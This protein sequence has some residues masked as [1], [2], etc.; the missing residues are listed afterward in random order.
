METLAAHL[1]S[2]FT[3][4]PDGDVEV[5]WQGGEPTL[6]GLDFFTHVV[7]IAEQVRRPGQTPRY[8]LQTNGTLI[9]DAWAQFLAENDFL[10]G[11]SVD[12]PAHLHD[13]F[14]TNVG[15]RETYAM[16]KRGWDTLQRHGVETNILCTVNAANQHHPLEVYRH[17]RDDLGARYIQF[18]PIVER[19]TSSTIAA[20]ERGW[21]HA[22]NDAVMYRQEGDLV[23]RRSVDPES[24]GRFLTVVF[25]EWVNHDVGEVSILHFDAMIGNVFGQSI[26]CVHA[27][28][29]GRQLV[30]NVDGDVYACDHYVEP[31]YRRGNVRS[32]T[33][34]EILAGDAQ[35]GF[36]VA[37][38]STLT[39]QCRDCRVRWA[40]HGGCPKDRFGSSREGE[41]GHSYLCSGYLDFFT[42]AEPA[43]LRLANA[44][45]TGGKAGT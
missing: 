44:V 41:A 10:V 21:G 31:E 43:I 32:D 9:D 42:H 30:T 29:C 1:T 7:E 27:P 26:L 13:V 18:I 35:Q 14:R 37:K 20:I 2:L 40:C 22:A 45:A 11:V 8:T 4:S 17:F 15:G 16:V 25:D 3:S 19:A 5:G 39:N 12:G 38:L 36:G 6:R 24:W 23:T 33:Y 28:T 34:E